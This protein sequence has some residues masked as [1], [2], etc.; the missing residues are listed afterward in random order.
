MFPWQKCLRRA[1]IPWIGE[2]KKV[3]RLWRLARKYMCVPATSTQAVRVFG[4]MDFLLN[5]RRLSLSGE[6][7]SMHLFLRDNIE[8]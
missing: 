4:W 5:K 1:R 2:A 7:V 8:L 3:R 6:R